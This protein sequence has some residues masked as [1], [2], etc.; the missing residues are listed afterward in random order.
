[1]L[2]S[3]ICRPDLNILALFQ[4]QWIFFIDDRCLVDE[5]RLSDLFNGIGAFQGCGFRG[6][7]F[8]GGDGGAETRYP[9]EDE[10]VLGGGK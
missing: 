2:E 10:G 1:M 9:G 5:V 7:A 6:R 4:T 8:G 3:C